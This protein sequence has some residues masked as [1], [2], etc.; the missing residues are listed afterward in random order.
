MSRSVKLGKFVC[1]TLLVRGLV[2]KI[3]FVMFLSVGHC[4]FMF[5][6]YMTRAVYTGQIVFEC[7]LSTGHCAV[8]YRQIHEITVSHRQKHDEQCFPDQ[9]TNEECPTDKYPVKS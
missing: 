4:N 2:W 5:L 7:F 3:F 9:A 8:S 6:V 1:G